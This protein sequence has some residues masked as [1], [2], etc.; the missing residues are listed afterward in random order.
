MAVG[1]RYDHKEGARDDLNMIKVWPRGE[2]RI[3]QYH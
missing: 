2:W 1:T 3:E